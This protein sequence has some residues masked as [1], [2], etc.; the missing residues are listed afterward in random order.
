MLKITGHNPERCRDCQTGR[1]SEGT[2][3]DGQGGSA[4]HNES[5]RADQG[6]EE[7]DRGA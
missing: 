7:T 3:C 5:E 1:R 6:G 2:G 4:G